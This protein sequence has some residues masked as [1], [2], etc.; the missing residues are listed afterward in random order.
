MGGVGGGER[1]ISSE[2]ASERERERE[3]DLP[4]AAE[5][6]GGGVDAAED[7]VEEADDAPGVHLGG[8]AGEADEVALDQRALGEA[9]RAARHPARRGD[10]VQVPRDEGRDEALEERLVGARPGAQLRDARLGLAP[11]GG[12]LGEEGGGDEEEDEGGADQVEAAEDPL[13]G[14]GGAV[15]GGEEWVAG[16]EDDAES[17]VPEYRLG[18]GDVGEDREGA[19][20]GIGNALEAVCAGSFGWSGFLVRS[21]WP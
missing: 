20:Q 16:D 12:E 19:G 21:A 4:E 7:A 9:V 10:A 13:E 14:G 15:E 17:E 5:R 8:E 3:V 18:D 6:V 1:E 2:R 11:P